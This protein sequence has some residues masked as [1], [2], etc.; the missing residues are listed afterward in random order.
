MIDIK[1]VMGV[2][3]CRDAISAG[4]KGC[5]QP[6]RQCRLAEFFHRNSEDANGQAFSN[7][8][9]AAARSSGVL[10]LKNGSS[11]SKSKNLCGCVSM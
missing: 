11:L 3:D 2:F 1:C 9:A 6:L 5:H 8:L 10:M 7:R 4:D